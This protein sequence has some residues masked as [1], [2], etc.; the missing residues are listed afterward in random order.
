MKL[1]NW[2]ED[3]SFRISRGYWNIMLVLS[4]IA[5]LMALAVLIWSLTPVIEQSVS[6]E[7]YPEPPSVSR[8]E[9]EN[10]LAP[11]EASDYEWE[12]PRAEPEEQ[13]NEEEKV[14]SEGDRGPYDES[15]ALLR[16]T[17]GESYWLEN[18]KSV[19]TL[20]V[21]EAELESA[22]RLT[23]YSGTSRYG[24]PMGNVTSGSEEA[25]VTSTDPS[26]AFTF[27]FKS[28]YSIT[29]TGW[30]I[31]ILNSANS[32]DYDGVV[33][34]P[35]SGE[36]VTDRCT[37]TDSGGRFG[38]YR[39]NENWSMTV[40][41][42]SPG[43][44]PAD[45]VTFLN[46]TCTDYACKADWVLSLNGALSTLNWDG[47]DRGE[48][49]EVFLLQDGW[50]AEKELL[51]EWTGILGSMPIDEALENIDYIAD[52]FLTIEPDY[53]NAITNQLVKSPSEKTDLLLLM[54]NALSRLPFAGDI[55]EFNQQS[56]DF[57]DNMQGW[58]GSYEE[59]YRAMLE[60]YQSKNSSRRQEIARIDEEFT[61]AEAEA[62]A[63][64]ESQREDKRE[65]RLTSLM[66]VGAGFSAIALVALLLV[67]LSIRR[68]LV[69][70]NEKK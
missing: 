37:L 60:I 63:E 2:L 64:A 33:R 42:K 45:L 1:F 65:L 54:S 38:N 9:I 17:L 23:V 4:G 52:A 13:P 7:E 67:L 16:G 59:A 14:D 62:E 51:S 24:T 36:L 61:E 48:A 30:S 18:S 34:M 29:K 66:G 49:M 41:P 44:A 55:E 43:E 70:L 21:S 68:L 5:L 26:G 56:S 22:D 20:Y 28:D 3:K 19:L 10:S 35:S 40:R 11:D 32:G 57:F 39:D 53:R 27:V 25:Y 69:E 46:E 8:A 50:A 31:E 6:K 15:L 47:E 12:E 58:N